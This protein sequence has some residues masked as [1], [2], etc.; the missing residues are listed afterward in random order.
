M[1]GN[2][3]SLFFDIFPRDQGVGKMLDTVGK[4]A[5]DAD[6]NLSGFRNGMN[7]LAA[8]AAGVL[9]G[10]GGIAVG[11]GQMA[12]EAEQN[13]GAVETVF[14]KASDKVNEF[15]ANSASAVGLSSSE[16]NKLSA[17]TGT[18]LK[19]AGVSV[20][21]LAQKNQALIERGADL[22]S[23][24]GGTTSEAVQ[25]MG[26]A[27]RGEFDSLERYGVTLTM[28]QV[29][30][31]L[32]ARGQDKLG[33]AALEAA[34]KQAIL[35]LIMKQSAGSAGNFAK[36]ADTT[37]G[38]QQRASAQFADASVKLGEKLLPALTKLAEILTGVAS[39]IAENSDLVAG[40]TAVLAILATGIIA[41]TGVMR[42]MNLTMAAN[43]I[44]LV[45]LAVSALIAVIVLLIMNWDKVIKFLRDSWSNFTAWFSNGMRRIGENWN[46]FWGGVGN[47]VRGVWNVTLGP[48][49]NGLRTMVTT[50]IPNAFRYGVGW[51]A[52]HWNKVQDIAKAPVRFLINTVINDGLIGTFN[53]V[54]EWVG[55]KT[56]IGR[57][58]LPPGFK[59][60]GYTGDGHE[61]EYAGAVHKG[62][63]VFPQTAVRRIG[64]ENLA[65]MAY[66]SAAQMPMPGSLPFINGPLQAQI[67]ATR[68]L[69]LVPI[70]GFP[71]REAMAAAY[72]WNGLAG[73]GIGVAPNSARE[74]SF[75]N[76]VFMGYGA[77]PNGA[78]G[79]YS[80]RHISIGAG[81]RGSLLGPTVVHEVGHALGLHHAPGQSSIMEPMLRGG[82]RVTAYDAANLRALY[83]GPGSAGPV[84]GIG[85]SNP[86]ADII[87]GLL[88]GLRKAFSGGFLVAE[89]AG[90]I[91]GKL[92]NGIKDLIDEKLGIGQGAAA[93]APKMF[94]NGGWF[95]EGYGVHRGSNPDA[96]LTQP[97]W[98][99]IH[100][101]AMGGGG[102]GKVYV[103]NPW[104]GEYM[105]ARLKRTVDNTFD[106]SVTDLGFRRPGA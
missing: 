47:R 76:S 28:N 90:G 96:V 61:D 14:G 105:E 7:K 45:I 64:K 10:L 31:E 30:A 83:G 101:L 57:V 58:G 24:F 104:T 53:K 65:A 26:A 52:T 93:M 50:T 86:I 3:T 20:D 36:E 88:G 17:T 8:P 48:I 98:N 4:K 39:W 89:L 70:G 80:G 99:D 75:T 62:E 12:A 13:V 29:N 27:F 55:L 32:A 91:A 97:Q 84:E 77:V 2:S 87:G 43:P 5:Q 15:A 103:E 54:A 69:R 25:A 37:A 51:I 66:G 21:Q 40:L 49:F 79:Y 33:G 94:D 9:A 42:I 102:L 56:R 41:A 73:V 46:N 71:M 38:A 67:R 63:F 100:A 1:P 106:S 23:V 60:G 16:Y 19:S 6:K 44:G 72:A 78:I 68:S 92:L 22:A 34:K 11:M 82:Y 95:H 74:A 59:S 18:A 35:D 81:A 85:G